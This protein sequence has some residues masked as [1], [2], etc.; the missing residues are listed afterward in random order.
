MQRAFKSRWIGHQL[1][2]GEENVGL[3]RHGGQRFVKRNQEESAG[4]RRRR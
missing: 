4:A 1:M 3:R 2:V